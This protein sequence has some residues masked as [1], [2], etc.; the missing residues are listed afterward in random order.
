MPLLEYLC[1]LIIFLIPTYLIRFSVFGI[2]TNFLEVLVAGVF[3][4]WLVSKKSSFL[5]PHSS[6]L[7]GVALMFTGLLIGVLISPDWHKSLG[8]L[9]G[10][11]LIPL[12]FS[13]VVHS[14]L[15]TREKKERAFF[16]LAVSGAC[17]AL[18]ALSYWV[19]GITT[20]DSRLRAFYES[21]NILAMYIASAI[22]IFSSRNSKTFLTGIAVLTICLLLTHSLGAIIA[23]SIAFALYSFLK[24]SFQKRALFLFWSVV[25]LSFVL[26]LI[27]LVINP[28]ALARN[29]FTSRLMIWR[30]ALLI[31]RDHWFLGIGAGTFQQSY[32]AYQKNFP[33]YLEWAVPHP[34]NIFLATWLYAG[35]L[36]LIGFFIL[37]ISFFRESSKNKNPTALIATGLMMF[38]LLSGAF[39]NSLWRNDSAMIFWLIVGAAMR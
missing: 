34:H 13:L 28:W 33:P 18:I 22:L 2:P 30:S 4:V 17:I 10:W 5:I 6:F 36:G 32:L 16:W 35:I 31:A 14:V 26:P 20:F 11:F 8:A 39:D 12:L 15:D 37:L 38:I 25:A 9:K 23:L 29:S 7:L 27:S 21:P 24:R 3:M 1:Y 19:L